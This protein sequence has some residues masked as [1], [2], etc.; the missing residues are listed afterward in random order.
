MRPSRHRLRTFLTVAVVFAVG[1]PPVSAQGCMNL[2][3]ANGEVIR[4]L[5]APPSLPPDHAALVFHRSPEVTQA[6]DEKAIERLPPDLAEDG[7][8]QIY[9]DVIMNGYLRRVFQRNL[10]VRGFSDHDLGD[11]LATHLI[12][13]WRILDSDHGEYAHEKKDGSAAVR[14]AVREILARS[15]WPRE[16][17]D[18]EKQVF[19]DTLIIDVMV[20]GLRYTD[21]SSRNRARL[22]GVWR[23]LDEMLIGCGGPD[24]AFL[25]LRKAGITPH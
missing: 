16:L 5:D 21:A 7:V 13:I 3:L 18:V 25:Y 9:V 23:E 12:F 6:V 15:A 20:L 8:H 1:L 4:P 19:A 24:R 17:D 10:D 14:D 2:V 22:G 11:V